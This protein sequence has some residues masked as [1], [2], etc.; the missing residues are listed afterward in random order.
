MTTNDFLTFELEPLS[1]AADRKAE[2][3]YHETVMGKRNRISIGHPL[4]QQLDA[5]VLGD[6][7]TDDDL[8]GFASSE[9]DFWSVEFS[10]TLLPDDACRFSSA[11]LAVELAPLDDVLPIIRRFSPDEVANSKTVR[12]EK[13]VNLSAGIAEAV[14][15]LELGASA[16]QVREE[17]WEHTA[18][19][20][21]SFGANTRN[22][23]WRLTVTGA[24][25][26]P[27][28]TSG[29][30][31][32]C[33]LPRGAHVTARINLVAGIDIRNALDRWVTAAFR[34]KRGTVESTFEI[35]TNSG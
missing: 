20:L 26:I 22:G 1:T 12:V 15:V 33:V 29:L 10:V 32:L 31:M 9:H 35:G 14:Q 16:K 19:S 6:L 5:E 3:G 13:Q 2:S 23:G 7:L 8:A 27:F 34:G 18:V 25:E 30:R 24:K 17:Q 4:V 11:D 21:A 28:N